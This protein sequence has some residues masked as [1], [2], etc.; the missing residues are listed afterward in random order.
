MCRDDPECVLEEAVWADQGYG[1]ARHQS[2]GACAGVCHLHPAAQRKCGIRPVVLMRWATNSRDP[3]VSTG[4]WL[5]RMGL[6]VRV[7]GKAI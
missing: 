6:A 4:V 3:Q 7:T 1:S 5:A 2:L